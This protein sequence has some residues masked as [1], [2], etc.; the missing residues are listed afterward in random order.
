M[1]FINLNKACLNGYFPSLSINRVADATVKYEFLTTMDVL[2]EYHQ[3]PMDLYD[4][5]KTS[6]IIE[7]RCW[8]LLVNVP[9]IK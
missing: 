6:F 4:K 7:K 1:D 9:S 2:A 3:I 5:D 8:K